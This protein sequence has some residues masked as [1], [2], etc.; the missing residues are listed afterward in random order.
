[1]HADPGG[2]CGCG[3]YAAGRMYI[4]IRADDRTV[5]ARSGAYGCVAVRTQRAVL[6]A[7]HDESI[8][9]GQCVNMV[10]RLADYMIGIGF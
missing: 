2:T 3:L 10:E 4:T 8:Q 7:H 1:M 5:Y 6:V 9:P